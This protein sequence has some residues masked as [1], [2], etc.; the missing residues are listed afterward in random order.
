MNVGIIDAAHVAARSRADHSR[1]RRGRRSPLH[2][3]CSGAGSGGWEPQCVVIAPPFGAGGAVAPQ[4]LVLPVMGFERTLRPPQAACGAAAKVR[5]HPGLSPKLLVAAR[6]EVLGAPSRLLET[7]RSEIPGA[8]GRVSWVLPG[9]SCPS[10]PR[11]CRSH[12]KP[13]WRQGCLRTTLSRR[14]SLCVLSLC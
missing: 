13:P 7:A 3:C 12:T 8:P 9:Q 10:P 14:L 5:A 1:L 11:R 6:S 4:A 2:P